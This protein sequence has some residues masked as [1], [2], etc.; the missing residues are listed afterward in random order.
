MRG[1][2]KIMW[3]DDSTRKS[4]N[5]REEWH[6][7]NRIVT[8]CH[9]NV[10]KSLDR[11]HFVLWKIFH[12]HWKVIGGIVV[13][14][15]ADNVVETNPRTKIKFCPTTW[16]KWR[17]Q[18]G[19]P[20]LYLQQFLFLPQ[21]WRVFSGP[22][23]HKMIMEGVDI[24]ATCDQYDRMHK[25]WTKMYSFVYVLMRL[26]SFALKQ[27]FFCIL[28][29]QTRLVMSIYQHINKRIFFWPPFMHSVFRTESTKLCVSATR[30]F[31]DD[32]TY[33]IPPHKL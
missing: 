24:F 15:L 30:N 29:M 2:P 17:L 31:R 9:H 3:M 7:R 21:T 11:K 22:I 18:S 12:N 6:H 23:I 10:V 19:F 8:I 13:G 28:S 1:I 25:C 16:Y 20:W 27:P 26:T 5:S 33:S 4:I 32:M 14:D